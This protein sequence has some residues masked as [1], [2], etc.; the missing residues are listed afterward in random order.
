M[1]TAAV[2]FSGDI[3]ENQISTENAAM[4]KLLIITV[5]KSI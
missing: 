4:E 1:N 5:E 3:P 2:T